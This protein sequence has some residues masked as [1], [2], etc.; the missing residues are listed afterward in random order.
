[1][2]ENEASA[3]HVSSWSIV[4]SFLLKEHSYQNTRLSTS[5]NAVW[6]RNSSAYSEPMTSH[7]LAGIAGSRRMQRLATGRRSG[8]HL[9]TMTSYPLCQWMRTLYLLEPQSGRVFA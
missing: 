4:H 1:M 7:A 2:S 8:R 3:A 9:E 5:A 6:A